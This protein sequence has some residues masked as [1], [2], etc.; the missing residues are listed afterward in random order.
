VLKVDLID[1]APTAT[2]AN[3]SGKG[4]GAMQM[5]VGGGGAGPGG[6]GG[7]RGERSGPGGGEGVHGDMLNA[8]A[9]PFCH[10]RRFGLHTGRINGISASLNSPLVIT[11]GADKTVR[12]WDYTEWRCLIRHVLPEEPTDVSCHPSGEKREE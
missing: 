7:G 5:M 9:S 4:K 2:A 10:L 6:G 8:M 12:V 1:A 3:P 11:C